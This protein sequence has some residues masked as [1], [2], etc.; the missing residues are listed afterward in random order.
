MSP[1][2]RASIASRLGISTNDAFL[3][4]LTVL[5]TMGIQYVVDV[6]SAADVALLEAREQFMERWSKDDKH[7]RLCEKPRVTMKLS[8]TRLK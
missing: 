2:S 4:V 5:K 1:Q 8:T 7:G 6:A 3:L